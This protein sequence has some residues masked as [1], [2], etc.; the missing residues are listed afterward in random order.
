MNRSRRIK[1]HLGSPTKKQLDLLKIMEEADPDDVERCY[2]III[3]QERHDLSPPLPSMSKWKLPLPPGC[4]HTTVQ[5]TKNKGYTLVTEPY[6]LGL[7]TLKR[8]VDYCE[9]YN[10]GMCL[11]GFST[12]FPGRTLMVMYKQHTEIYGSQLKAHASQTR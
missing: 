11:S 7:S 5:G 12:H 2:A 6:E 4:D 1:G 9:K 8:I 10:V 3:G